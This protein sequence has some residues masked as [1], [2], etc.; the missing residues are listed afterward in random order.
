ML[1]VRCDTTVEELWRWCPECGGEVREE[2]GIGLRDE[3]GFAVEWFADD[4]SPVLADLQV[5]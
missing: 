2:P 4:E 3:V 5:S 1:C